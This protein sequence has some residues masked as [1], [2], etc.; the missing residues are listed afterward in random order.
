MTGYARKLE[1]NL[2]MFF[3]IRDKQLL[4]KCDKIWKRTEKLFY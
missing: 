1:F 4:K 3:K 2:T